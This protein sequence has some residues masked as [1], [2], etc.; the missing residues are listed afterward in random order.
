MLCRERQERAENKAWAAA[1]AH[2]RNLLRSIFTRLR[3]QGD[4]AAEDA[5]QAA[6]GPLPLHPG[7]PRT[8]GVFSKMLT[9]QD[10]VYTFLS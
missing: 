3:V 4:Y 10:P 1:E 7:G 8:A 6:A 9:G 5:A 2:W